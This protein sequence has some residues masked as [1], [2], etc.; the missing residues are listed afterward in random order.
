[1][2]PYTLALVL[3]RVAGAMALFIGL[4]EL[5]AFP[6]MFVLGVGPLKSFEAAFDS[7]SLHF[8]TSGVFYSVAG[9]VCLGASRRLARIASKYCDEE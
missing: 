3:I 4:F 9:A 8:A 7:G 1:M 2:K 6:F 5:V